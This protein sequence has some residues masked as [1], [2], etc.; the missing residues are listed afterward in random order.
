MQVGNEIF[1]YSNKNIF[2]RNGIFLLSITLK[3]FRN[4]PLFVSNGT[5]FCSNETIF[6]SDMI[7]LFRNG[8]KC[9]GITS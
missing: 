9:A 7:Y 6:F 4:K 8:K 2:Y 1:I 5:I 3:L